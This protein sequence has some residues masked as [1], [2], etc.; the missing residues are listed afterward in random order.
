VIKE[1]ASSVLSGVDAEL[2]FDELLVVP[3]EPLV[4]VVPLEPE[5]VS[6]GW[7]RLWMVMW[8]SSSARVRRA[9]LAC[10]VNRKFLRVRRSGR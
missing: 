8:C 2:V 1:L 6:N 3:L 5:V 9:R 4:P 7:T 10:P